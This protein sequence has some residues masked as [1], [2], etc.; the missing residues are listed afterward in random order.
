MDPSHGE[1][2]ALF[3]KARVNT[4]ILKYTYQEIKPVEGWQGKNKDLVFYI[5]KDEKRLLDLTNA[6]LKLGIRIVKEDKTNFHMELNEDGSINTESELNEYCIPIDCIFHTMWK[7]VEIQYENDKISSSGLFYA[8]KAFFDIILLSS[9]NEKTYLL[10]LIGLAMDYDNYEATS[11]YQKPSNRG[12][13]QRYEMTRNGKILY[14]CGKIMDD[15]CMQP[16]LLPN[17][18][19]IKIEFT[20]NADEFRLMKKPEN[21]AAHLEMVEPILTV[22]KVTLVEPVDEALKNMV[23]E[24]PLQYPQRIG[25]IKTKTIPTDTNI[26]EFTDIFNNMIPNKLVFGFVDTKA[27]KGNFQKNPLHFVNLDLTN[28]SL[29]V[30]SEF[31]PSKGYT[32]DFATGKYADALDALY[33]IFEKNGERKDIGITREQFKEGLC[34][35]AFDITP[36]VPGDLSVWGLPFTGSLDLNLTFKNSVEKPYELIMYGIFPGNLTIDNSDKTAAEAFQLK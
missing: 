10:H 8:Y 25:K 11:P 28:A 27:Y 35:I 3:E 1:N 2:I 24:Q 31:V 15:L 9:Y 6:F 20:H 30:G 4:A 17:T 23:K 22:G 16:H 36:A 14:M 34:L 18:R 19:D 26:V 33:K 21:L 32:L 29:M 12:L 5:K 7:T 13:Q